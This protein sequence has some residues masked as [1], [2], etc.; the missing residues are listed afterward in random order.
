M[1]GQA[2]EEVRGMQREQTEKATDSVLDTL[3]S[4]SH[5]AFK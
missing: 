3:H 1:T 4:R 2:S 5:G